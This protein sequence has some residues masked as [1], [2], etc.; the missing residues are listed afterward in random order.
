MAIPLEESKK[1]LFAYFKENQKAYLKKHLRERG[2]I[3]RIAGFSAHLDKFYSGSW[4]K[5]YFDFEFY[6]FVTTAQKYLS[7]KSLAAKQKLEKRLSQLALSLGTSP[8]D[9]LCIAIFGKEVKQERQQT[10]LDAL[11]SYITKIPPVYNENYISG[12]LS[13]LQQKRA[14]YSSISEWIATEFNKRCLKDEAKEA[15][16]LFKKHPDLIK[17][18]SDPDVLWAFTTFLNKGTK[19]EVSQFYKAVKKYKGSE[20]V[21]IIETTQKAS[22]AINE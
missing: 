12:F 1:E 8:E 21:G 16:H 7:L 14:S 13:A 18:L 22:R 2:D 19:K 17:R 9:R 3:L 5:A 6:Q 20:L 15:Y 10:L 11:K 4:Q